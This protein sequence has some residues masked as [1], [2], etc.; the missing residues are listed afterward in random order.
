MKD[1]CIDAR[2]KPIIKTNKISNFFLLHR[3]SIPKPSGTVENFS[4]SS[5]ACINR[6]QLGCVVFFWSATASTRI[7]R[8]AGT[9]QVES[10][11]KNLLPST[12]QYII[13]STFVISHIDTERW[14]RAWNRF[15]SQFLQSR[16]KSSPTLFT[17]SVL[18]SRIRLRERSAVVKLPNCTR[19][20]F[21]SSSLLA[22]LLR[23]HRHWE[24][25]WIFVKTCVHG[26]WCAEPEL[27]GPTSPDGATALQ[28][29]ST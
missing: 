25:P 23:A 24:E 22:L 29:T 21:S 26:G 5:D 12:T 2:H 8:T 1:F 16:E 10:R 3:S 11:K 18:I 19:L 6:F 13:P 14:K 27:H 28:W 7:K 9:W 20:G 4:A 15:G 17:L